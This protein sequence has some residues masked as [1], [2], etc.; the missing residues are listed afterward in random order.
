M[1]VW[2]FLSS[3]RADDS[4]QAAARLRLGALSSDDRVG[5]LPLTVVDYSRPGWHCRLALYDAQGALMETYLVSHARNSGDYVSAV[6]FSNEMDSN[7]SS[8]GLFRITG[9][10]EGEHGIAL[11]LEGLDPGLNDRA[12]ER[13]IVIHGADYVSLWSILENT[14]TGKGPGVGRSLG[15]PAVSLHAM[16]E[17]AE[18]LSKG[19]YLYFHF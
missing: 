11:R 16:P 3:S 13:A 8:L 14:V 1:A 9:V 15:C 7:Q 4:A 18:T 5:A 17:L 2:A 10:Y 12:H 19:G 6:S